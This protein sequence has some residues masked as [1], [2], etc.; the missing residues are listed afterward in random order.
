MR[1]LLGAALLSAALCAPARADGL[2]RLESDPS[3]EASRR[4][5]RLLRETRSRDQRF[6]LVRALGQRLSEFGD[7]SALEPLL[8]ACADKD[9]GVRAPALRALE[10]FRALPKDKVRDRW[11][12]RLDAA[13]GKGIKDPRPEVRDGARFLREALRNWRHSDGAPVPAFRP[14]ADRD[15]AGAYALS[16]ALAW[17]WVLV[18]PVLA[19][20]WTRLGFPLAARGE[21]GARLRACWTYLRARPVLLAAGMAGW[22]VFAGVVAGLG[23]DLVVLALGQPFFEPL[24]GWPKDA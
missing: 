21:D 16:R 23:F 4:L 1:R 7:E 17:L 11:L 9:P 12:G 6:W 8:L 5:G 15:D 18:L 10:G 14:S 20:V 22:S 2:K 24:R 3:P 13:A 19:W